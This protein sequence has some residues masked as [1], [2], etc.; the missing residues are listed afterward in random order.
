MGGTYQDL[1]NSNCASL[2]SSPPALSESGEI[3]GFSIVTV[4]NSMDE[5]AGVSLQLIN[6]GNTDEQPVSSGNGSVSF[7][8]PNGVF[9]ISVDVTIS[10]S[11]CSNTSGEIGTYT[12]VSVDS[13]STCAV[14]GPSA[15]DQ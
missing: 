10:G 9:L 2:T 13:D 8:I 5:A 15:W 12:I 7:T 6:A 14:N 1:L 4:V 11:T 3:G